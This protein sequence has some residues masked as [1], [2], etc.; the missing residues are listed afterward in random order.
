MR[1][2]RGRPGWEGGGCFSGLGPSADRE[3]KV[4]NEV[5][6]FFGQGS[7]RRFCEMA[8]TFCN[9]GERQHHVD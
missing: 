8:L 6:G 7:D 1:L 2:V 3:H 4:R 9:S 5:R